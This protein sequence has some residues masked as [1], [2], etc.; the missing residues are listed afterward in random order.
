MHISLPL[1][2]L[3]LLT[4]RLPLEISEHGCP[5]FLVRFAVPERLGRESVKEDP[6]SQE[7]GSNELFHSMYSGKENVPADVRLNTKLTVQTFLYIRG[8][9]LR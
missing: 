8:C 3:G 4:F 6:P 7:S 9:L 2:P 1:R 5:V